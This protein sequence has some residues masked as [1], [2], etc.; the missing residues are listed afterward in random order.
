[1]TPH[2]CPVCDLPTKQRREPW[3]RACDTCG[4]EAS[5]FEPQINATVAHELIDES[6]RE[7]GLRDLRMHNFRKLVDVIG[8]LAPK[9]GRLIDVGAA[10]G[11][12]LDAACKRFSV[13]GI[14]PDR[15]VY[16]KTAERGLPMRNGFFPAALAADEKADVIVFNDVI[17]HIPAIDTI[18][19]ACHAHLSPGGVL[20]INLPS[21]NGL[22]YRIAKGLSRVGATS[23]LSRLWQ[24][25][26]PSP[27]IHYFNAENLSRLLKKHSFEPVRAGRLSTLRYAGLW[28][29]ISHTGNYGPVM[30]L[31]LALSIAVAIP[32]LC[33]LPGDIIYIA[34]RSRSPSGLPVN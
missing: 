17:E 6:G 2:Q 28:T 5:T 15:G 11:W 14:E 23:F 3:R 26:L 20:L 13:L 16:A 4:Y 31:V 34:S 33:V 21:S 9:G 25:D 19:D 32:F 27:H 10:H 29:R 1:M 24:K 30:R 18:L 12:F 22:F 8:E 7:A